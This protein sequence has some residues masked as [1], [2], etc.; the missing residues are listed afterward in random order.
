MDTRED[1]EITQIRQ[2]PFYAFHEWKVEDDM[3]LDY[4]H[5]IEVSRS[6]ALEE[7]FWTIQ[8]YRCL[9]KGPC[10]KISIKG[11]QFSMYKKEGEI[12]A[13]EAWNKR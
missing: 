10:V 12:L 9:A 5:A 7:S 4:L 6:E 1:K 13:W 3:P 2:C 11:K 8:C